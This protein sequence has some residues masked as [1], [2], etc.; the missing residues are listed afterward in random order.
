MESALLRLL[1]SFRSVD[2]HCR[3]RQLLFLIGL[4]F[5]IFSSETGWPNVPKLGKMHLWEV[6]YK[7]YSFVPIHLQRW[8]PQAILVSDWSISKNLLL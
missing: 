6:L 2:K 8:P 5:L 1:I 3:N 7:V 4:F